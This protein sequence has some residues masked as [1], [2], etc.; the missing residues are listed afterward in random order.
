MSERL[1]RLKPDPLPQITAVAERLATGALRST[2]EETKT[3]L[4]VPW[5]GVVAMAF[6]HYPTFY[7][8][9]WDGLVPVVRCME[10]HDACV[11]LRTTAE[12]AATQ[13]EPPDILDRL[14]ALGYSDFEIKEVR[15]CNEI[16]SAGNMPYLLIA[17]CARLLLEGHEWPA[18]QG[19]T[20]RSP[21]VPHPRPALMEAHHAEADITALYEDIRATLG[22]PFV[23]T[24][25]RAF[26]RWPSYFGM[27]WADLRPH[28][29]GEPYEALVSQVHDTVVALAQKLPNPKELQVATL[30]EAAQSD[31]PH[32]DVLEVVRLFQW[33]L[34][35]LALNVAFFH[36][37]LEK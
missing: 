22:L 19:T 13:L 16:F 18:H 30:Q 23:N 10:F 4:G 26:A 5:M 12:A 14:T 1:P 34:P 27:A 24:D 35:G 20:L 9:L 7:R 37:Q 21:R 2:Y 8:A 31:A 36:L 17:T 25:Y 11:A 3:A 15:A 6:A 32:G 29:G 33:L 28:I